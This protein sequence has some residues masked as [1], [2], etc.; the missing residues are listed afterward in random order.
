MN[1]QAVPGIWAATSG[2][3]YIVGLIGCLALAPFA[4]ALAFAAG[5]A[6]VL[7]NSF[8]SAR[9]IRRAP[10]PHKGPAMA[11]VLGWFYVRLAVLAI[12]LFGLIRYSQLDP[13]GLVAGLSVVPAGLFVMLALIYFANRRPEEV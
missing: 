1:V 3:V 13:L 11:S 7:V 8:A 6:L 9:C 2:V 10:F 12:C 4:F 5:G